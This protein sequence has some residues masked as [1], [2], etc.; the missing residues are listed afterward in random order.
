MRLLRGSLAA[1]LLV[2]AAVYVAYRLE[3]PERHDL[4]EAARAVAPGRF[5]RLADGVTHYEMT[6][7]DTG[8]VVV[9]AAGFSV[10]YYIW[11]SLYQ[12]LADSGFRV[13]RY[14]Y[15]GRGWSDRVDATYDQ[16][17]FVRQLAGLLDSL[18]IRG[19]VDL[20][21]LSFGGAIVTSFA[22]RHPE[23][24]RSLIYVDPGFNNGRRLRPEERTKLAWNLHMIFGGGSDKMAEDQLLD[25]LHPERHPDWP[26]RFRVQ[27]RF[28]GTREAL[29]KTRVAIAVGPHQG[30]ELRRLGAHPRP[31]LVIWGRQDRVVPFAE[32]AA[33]LRAM[34]RA[35]LAPIDSAA[36]LPHL[37]QPNAVAGAVLRFLRGGSTQPAS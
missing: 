22:D 36:H 33:L 37:E 29:R 12:R 21:G 4:D 26:A 35:R 30:E 9:L 17:L 11:D 34:P 16:D 15:Y 5:V 2:C 20:A 27:Q 3:D 13:I 10:P 25:F 7:P 8:R 23:R 31:V 18:R 1:M 24:V 19:M 6:G 32:S 14:D 28:I